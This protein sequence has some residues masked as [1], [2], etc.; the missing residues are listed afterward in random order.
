MEDNNKVQFIEETGLLMESFGMTR[1]SGRI[2]GVLLVS[3]KEKVSFYEMVE[4]LQASK[5]SISTNLRLLTGIGF[6]KMISMPADRKTYYI[7]NEDISWGDLL[8]KRMKMLSLFKVLLKKA[9]ELRVDKTDKASKWT[10]NAIGFYEW[11][12]KVMT[13][14]ID[15]YNK[16]EISKK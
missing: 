15:K 1:M 7:L 12:E 4:L 8:N 6:V 16:T 9:F 2:L 10:A 14:M 5:S 3:D 13:E 11:T